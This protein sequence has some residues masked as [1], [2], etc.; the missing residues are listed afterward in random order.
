MWT[1]GL[2]IHIHM[3]VC[4][5]AKTHHA[6]EISEGPRSWRRQ[7]GFAQ[8]PSGRDNTLNSDLWSPELTENK[9]LPH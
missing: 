3:Y 1:S 6:K 5:C 4:T 8:A 2:Y 7:E 9:F